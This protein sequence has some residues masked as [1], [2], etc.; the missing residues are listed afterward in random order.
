MNHS[1][2]LQGIGIV[3]LG[4]LWLVLGVASLE[5]AS[6]DAGFLGRLALQLVLLVAAF[7]IIV[8]WRAR[9]RSDHKPH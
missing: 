2:K 9:H 4:L 7:L 1:P 6:S 3:A 8:S 5:R